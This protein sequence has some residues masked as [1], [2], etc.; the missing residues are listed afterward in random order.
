M[1]VK[2]RIFKSWTKSWETL[3]AE[4][5]VFASE[6]GRE[7]LISVSLSEDQHEGVI[8]VWYWE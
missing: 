2:F 4:A 5:A 6:K 7:R 8:V 3:C 1:E